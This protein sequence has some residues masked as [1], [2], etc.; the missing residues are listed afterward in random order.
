MEDQA[1]SVEYPWA[2]SDRRA[3]DGSRQ[4]EAK[5]VNVDHV[6]AGDLAPD[7]VRSEGDGDLRGT[8]AGNSHDLQTVLG[9]AD[10]K[11]LRVTHHVAVQGQDRDLT[12][13]GRLCGGEIVNVLLCAPDQGSIS[14]ADV[15]DANRRFGRHERLPVLVRRQ[16]SQVRAARRQRKP[17]GA[18]PG[19]R[20]PT[21]ILSAH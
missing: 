4:G 7:A 14:P 5:V 21:G 9:F 13:R 6:V 19:R 20:P 12:A 3:D 15:E 16:F 8:P 18:C 10:G 2:S 11:T 1:V 17:L